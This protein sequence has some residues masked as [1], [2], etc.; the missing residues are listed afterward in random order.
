MGKWFTPNA[1][2][3]FH[4][5]YGPKDHSSKYY[6][7]LTNITGIISKPKHTM[8][9]PDLPS[10]MR[11]VTHREAVPLPKPLENLT[12][13]MTTL[14]LKKIMDSQNGTRLIVI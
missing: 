8:K 7:C 4:G 13:V 3:H 14:I 5:L 11:P 12:S 2:H 9:N 1:V 10:A 6:F